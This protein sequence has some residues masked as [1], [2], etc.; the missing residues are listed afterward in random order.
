MDPQSPSN[1]VVTGGC[2]K[3]CPWVDLVT[4]GS[5]TNYPTFCNFTCKI[6]IKWSWAVRQSIFPLPPTHTSDNVTSFHISFNHC[7]TYHA[8]TIPL[9]IA[10]LYLFKTLGAQ[11]TT[12]KPAYCI[13]HSIICC[14]HLTL[15]V[16]IHIYISIHIDSADFRSY[17]T[18]CIILAHNNKHF[19]IFL[20]YEN[21]LPSKE[22]IIL[23]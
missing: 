1:G 2:V 16:H 18:Y 5:R 9:S 8:S 4:A 11:R 21:S 14:I 12:P 19:H 3:C 23:Q 15:N 20:T 6:H 13:W 17:V 7:G 10:R 22:N